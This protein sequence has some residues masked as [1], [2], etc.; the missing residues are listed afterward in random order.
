[1]EKIKTERL[2]L[3]QLRDEDAPALTQAANNYEVIKWL[4]LLPYPYTLDDAQWFINSIR[5]TKE[6][7]YGVFHK[8]KY[9]GVIG[10][11]GLL[12]LGYWFAQEAWGKGFGTEAATAVVDL[13]FSDPEAGDLLSSY[14]VNNVGSARIQEKLGFKIT[15]RKMVQ[16]K[17]LDEIEQVKTVLTRERW[18]SL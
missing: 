16:R 1:M 17:Y 15:S 7:P 6:E 9:I 13:H 2:V 10:A 14:V 12:G 8:D 3:R 18:L 11:A 5:D 4:N